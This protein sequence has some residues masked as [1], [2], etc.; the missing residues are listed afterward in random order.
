MKGNSGTFVAQDAQGKSYRIHW[1][2]AQADSIAV[3]GR[4]DA[5]H[6]GD[7][8]FRTDGGTP[9]NRVKKGVYDIAGI[10]TVRLTSTDPA[11]P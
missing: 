4:Q 11:E 7:T 8:E 6:A 10:R 5:T 9:V 2:V 3:G 1:R